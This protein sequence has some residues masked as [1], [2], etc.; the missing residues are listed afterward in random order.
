[1]THRLSSNRA[2][3]SIA[4]LLAACSR[5]ESPAPSAKAPSS[6]TTAAQAPTIQPAP[7]TTPSVA[8]QP[9]AEPLP[10]NHVRAQ[11]DCPDGMIFVPGG[12]FS[13]HGK[14]F[15][16]ASD[17][18]ATREYEIKPFCID[19]AEVSS[20]QYTMTCRSCGTAYGCSRSG[21]A[22]TCTTREQSSEYCGVRL[23]EGGRLPTPEEF[24]YAALGG[25]SQAFPW[26][27]TFYP[28][29][30]DSAHDRP[31]SAPFCDWEVN[32]GQ[33]T[34]E[35]T[36]LFSRYGC[37]LHRP[38]LDVS[39][40]GVRNLASNVLE[41]TAGSY[42]DEQGQLRCTV[43]GLDFSQ[44]TS[45]GFPPGTDMVARPAVKCD[46]KLNEEQRAL[47][48]IGFRCATSVKR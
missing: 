18:A 41:W 7:V 4:L 13:Y 39:A 48:T 3:L 42:R 33:M 12:H 47:D 25:K 5:N 43:L 44:V 35:R 2:G 6:V 11:A 20:H 27:N 16:G 19:E 31:A 9:T 28:W 45:T 37:A 14:P 1:M 15:D 46:P 29:G 40:S 38:S 24:I 17:D 30:N 32:E 36:V 26:G 23:G 34:K 10:P 8:S 22:R 21:D